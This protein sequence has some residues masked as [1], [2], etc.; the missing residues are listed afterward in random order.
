MVWRTARVL[1]RALA[2]RT[3]TRSELRWPRLATADLRG[4]QVLEVVSVGKHLLARI[5]GRGLGQTP[6]TLHSHLRM[7]G[8]WRVQRSARPLPFDAG[9]SI[10]A[11]VANDSWTAV[12][13][14]LGMLD[15]VPTAAEHRLVGHLGPDL[16]GPDWDPAEAVRR[17][18][19]HGQ[20]PIGEALL[21]QTML[22]GVGTF[23]LCEG[24]FLSGVSPWT[25]TEQVRDLAALVDL[26]HRLLLSNRDRAEQCTTGDPRP[27]QRQWVFARPGRSC[28]RCGTR[29]RTG[30]V[31][32]APTRRTVFYCPQCQ[33]GPLP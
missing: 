15:L 9:D 30:A 23:Y 32:I 20:R 14:R 11:I 21:D 2:G 6:L 28:R 16:L 1:H 29:I 12:G 19:G 26:L 8:S 25:R 17:L 31:G 22:A 13:H 5:D 18:T 24:L 4:R 27:G 10:R 3:L 7:D 33:P